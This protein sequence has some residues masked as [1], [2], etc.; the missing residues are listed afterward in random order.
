G[1]PGSGKT[2]VATMLAE[3]LKY[4][5]YSCGQYMKQLAAKKEVSLNKLLEMAQKDPSIDKEIDDWQIQLGKKENNFVLDSRLGFHFIQKSFKVFLDVD[6]DVSVE[7]L[8]H[9]SHSGEHTMQE[10]KEFIQKRIDS[11]IL[12]F[13]KEYHVNHFDFSHYNLVLVTT[14]LPPEL[15]VDEIRDRI[16]NG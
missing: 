12:R 9:D 6:L 16:K 10:T 5:Y 4:K 7:R 1:K 13:S 15:I 2:T 3:T 8:Y 11:E 14:A